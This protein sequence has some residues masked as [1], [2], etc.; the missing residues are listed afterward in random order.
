LCLRHFR[1]S[2][3]G[4]GAEQK[5]AVAFTVGLLQEPVSSRS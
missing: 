1:Q 3:S 2:L 4:L 5:F